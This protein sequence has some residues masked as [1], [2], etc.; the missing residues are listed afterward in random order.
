M[1]GKR[2][3]RLGLL[4]RSKVIC[5]SVLR[6]I[7]ARVVGSWHRAK[8]RLCPWRPLVLV[9]ARRKRARR[10]RG[11]IVRAARAYVKALGVPPP[12]RLLVVVQRVVLDDEPLNALL[13]VFEDCDG[14]RRQ[15]LFLALS[16]QDRSVSDDE[17]V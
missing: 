15:V 2:R 6:W 8:R 13:Q 11:T 16:V 1:S 17:L 14:Q 5:S 10:L 7:R 3:T 12:E 9:D 4:P